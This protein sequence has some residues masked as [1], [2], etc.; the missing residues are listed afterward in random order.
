MEERPQGRAGA[1]E[2]GGRACGD[3][4][5]SPGCGQTLDEAREGS[6]QKVQGEHGQRNLA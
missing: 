6:L 1:S 5:T 4:A 3:T 2:G